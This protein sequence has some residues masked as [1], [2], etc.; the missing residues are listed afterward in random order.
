ML[1][2]LFI[3]L[4]LNQLNSQE[5]EAIE[6]GINY[7][8]EKYTVNYNM[9]LGQANW[10]MSKCVKETK[11]LSCRCD[12][13]PEWKASVNY[14]CHDYS[15][16]YN[17]L[18]RGHLVPNGEL[19]PVTCELT[20]AIPMYTNFNKIV[21]S[22]IEAELRRKYENRIIYRG[23]EYDYG[24]F[25]ITRTEKL[26]FV[27]T[28]CYFVVVSSEKNFEIIDYGFVQDNNAV[29]K[30]LP[31]WI[32]KNEKPKG[33]SLIVIIVLCIVICGVPIL[34]NFLCCY[35]VCKK[36]FQLPKL[37]DSTLKVDV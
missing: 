2:I 35:L 20:N 16:I 4:F 22:Y 32:K 11:Q 8:Y 31:W 36:E 15:A 30:V 28:G 13:A 19:G 1:R 12:I 5:Y 18:Q 14:T 10:A 34:Y 17:D 25:V 3:F 33:D 26:M 6:E 27:P 24:R 37:T 23:C 9:S 21:W 29:I 7:K